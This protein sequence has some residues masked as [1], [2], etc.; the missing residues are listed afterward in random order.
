MSLAH[1][2]IAWR[3]PSGK[4]FDSRV[5]QHHFGVPWC[6]SWCPWECLALWSNVRNAVICVKNIR[7]TSKALM[8][9]SLHAN[10]PWVILPHRPLPLTTTWTVLDSEEDPKH[11]CQWGVR[12][13]WVWTTWSAVSLPARSSLITHKG[14]HRHPWRIHPKT[15]GTRDGTGITAVNQDSLGSF[16][17]F[18]SLQ[19]FCL[20][21]NQVTSPGSWKQA[22]S[23]AARI[24][25]KHKFGKDMVRWK[26]TL[27]ISPT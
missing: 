3:T 19:K 27:F 9:R 5:A 10:T 21:M 7:A 23:C 20:L 22:K 24:Q 1:D 13:K 2:I 14:P 15:S 8:P 6:T 17:I 25:L 11:P 12:D 18:W 16:W 4:N 26:T